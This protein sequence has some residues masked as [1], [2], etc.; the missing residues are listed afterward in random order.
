MTKTASINPIEQTLI[1][2]CAGFISANGVGPQISYPVAKNM[3]VAGIVFINT[4]DKLIEC[5]TEDALFKF[6]RSSRYPR[7]DYVARLV[8]KR[9]SNA[10]IQ[11]NG[12]GGASFLEKLSSASEHQAAGLL[13]PLYGVGPKFVETF[14]LLAG[15]DQQRA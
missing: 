8:A 2:L 14:C 1:D 15:I 9:I 13:L 7:G 3:F 4:S 12:Q 6:L 11:V 5:A 10:I